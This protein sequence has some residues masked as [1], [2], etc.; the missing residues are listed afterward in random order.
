[1]LLLPQL[2]VALGLARY[3]IASALQD[4][5]SNRS[6]APRATIG[7]VCELRYGWPTFQKCRDAL[8]QIPTDP[9]TSPMPIL[10]FGPAGSRNLDF[11]LPQVF[12]S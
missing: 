4:I 2:F 6:L 5:T 9:T 8:A 7:P 3:V 1:M 12:S 11:A 10:T